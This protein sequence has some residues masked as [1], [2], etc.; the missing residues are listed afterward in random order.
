M[1]RCF[2]CDIHVNVATRFPG[3]CQ[4][5][6]LRWKRLTEE[7]DDSRKVSVFKAVIDNISENKEAVAKALKS[8]YLKAASDSRSQA[9]KLFFEDFHMLLI[10]YPQIGRLTFN[11]QMLAEK[12]PNWART[13]LRNAP[14]V[15][16]STAQ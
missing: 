14:L 7:T 9:A 6:A 12:R 11:L 15:A 4:A 1:K 16:S 8:Q 13:F 10:T 2:C 3:A 5:A